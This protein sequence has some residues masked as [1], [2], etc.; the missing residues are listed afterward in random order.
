[1]DKVEVKFDITR[2]KAIDMIVREN[3]NTK[4]EYNVWIDVSQAE[5]LDDA[6]MMGESASFGM[7]DFED[8]AQEIYESIQKE[9]KRLND[10]PNHEIYEEGEKLGL[11]ELKERQK[12]LTDI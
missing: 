12:R 10:L 4:V 9:N 5:S 6:R 11:W 8:E 1:M 3:V 2:E 7:P